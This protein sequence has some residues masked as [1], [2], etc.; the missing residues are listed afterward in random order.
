MCAKIAHTEALLYDNGNHYH[1]GYTMKRNLLKR[2]FTPDPDFSLGLMVL[3]AFVT[4]LVLHTI[5]IFI[6]DF[7]GWKRDLLNGLLIYVIYEGTR[8]IQKICTRFKR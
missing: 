6:P 7:K 2:C 4:F 8:R 5:S 3:A 1:Y